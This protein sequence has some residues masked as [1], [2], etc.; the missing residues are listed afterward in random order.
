M[1]W[2]LQELVT[3]I[4]F[5]WQDKCEVPESATGILYHASITILNKGGKLILKIVI[6]ELTD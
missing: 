6:T 5:D 2:T 1:R 4:K 3:T